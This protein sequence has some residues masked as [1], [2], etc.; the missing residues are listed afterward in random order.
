M[1]SPQKLTLVGLVL[2]M[3]GCDRITDQSPTEVFMAMNDEMC[4][5][6]DAKVMLHYVTDASKPIV[7]QLIL[8]VQQIAK[9]LPFDAI[10]E[11]SCVG[12]KANMQV[13][14]EIAD[15]TIAEITYMEGKE[16]KSI[17]MLR[18]NGAWKVNIIPPMDV[19]P[20]LNGEIPSPALATY[21]SSV[22]I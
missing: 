13:L 7:E 12:E 21:R 3:T 17:R 1:N 10:F 22:F 4:R 8:P 20:I 14:R 11:Q 6:R 15:K 16:V 19:S 2:A 18:E 5:T 9:A